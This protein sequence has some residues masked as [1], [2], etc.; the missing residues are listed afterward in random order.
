LSYGLE[1]ISVNTQSHKILINYENNR[2]GQNELD[3][4]GIVLGAA[5]EFGDSKIDTIFSLS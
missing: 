4:L 2:F 5:S 1:N 3:A